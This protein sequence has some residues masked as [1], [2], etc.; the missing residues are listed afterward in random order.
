MTTTPIECSSLCANDEP[1]SVSNDGKC[2]AWW[3]DEAWTAS[4]E[5]AAAMD[6]KR[7]AMLASFALPDGSKA[8][9]SMWD[10]WKA[11]C[12][13]QRAAEAIFF[14]LTSGGPPNGFIRPC[15]K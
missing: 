14:S 3:P 15:C 2:I 5:I 4:G 9:A 13:R 7:A 8:R 1:C 12:R 11:A 10:E 6:D